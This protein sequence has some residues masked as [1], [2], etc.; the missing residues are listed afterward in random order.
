MRSNIQV[1]FFTVS[2]FADS[3]GIFL[4]TDVMIFF[5]FIGLFISLW[6]VE[7]SLFKHP[8]SCKSASQFRSWVVSN[9]L[10]P[11]GLQHISLSCQHQL[12]ELAQ[13]NIS[14]ISDAI[15]PSHPLSFCSPTAF[16]RT[17]H[18]GLFQ[19]VSSSHL[20][21]K[22]LELQLQNLSRK[23]KD[24]YHILTHI[25]WIWKNGNDNLFTGQR[26]RNRHRE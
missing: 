15:L 21:A 17:Q 8:Y 25:Y 12:L 11:H 24:K 2:A 14:R 3:I 7:A 6:M 10:I 20:V 18:Q 9:S 16:N 23:E 19:G 13:T 4:Y 22:V 5:S 26:W 1:I